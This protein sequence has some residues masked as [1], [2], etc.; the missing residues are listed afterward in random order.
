[1]IRPSLGTVKFDGIDITRFKPYQIC[2]LGIQRTF[3]SPR[4]FLELTA[5]E[6]TLVS[7]LFG[8]DESTKSAREQALKS[9]AEVQVGRLTLIQR[10]TVELAM[11]LAN[12]PQMVLLDEIAAGLNPTE[13]LWAMKMIRRVRDELGITVFWIEHIMKAVMEI[14]EWI[15]VLHHGEKIAEGPPDEIVQDPIV[16]EAYLEEHWDGSIIE[17]C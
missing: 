15:L 17:R 8:R 10:K 14:A 5:L 6:N 7:V 16:L 3:Q 12:H 2:R 9:L 1:M 13:I 4:L 11:A